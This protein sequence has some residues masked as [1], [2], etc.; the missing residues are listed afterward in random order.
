[1]HCVGF[2]HTM[3]L[4]LH[5]SYIAPCV[6]NCCATCCRLHPSCITH[7]MSLYFAMRLHLYC[8]ICGSILFN[9]CSFVTTRPRTLDGIIFCNVSSLVMCNMWQC[10]IQCLFICNHQALHIACHY[11]LQCFFIGIVQYVAVYYAVPVHL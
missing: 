10:T 8:A 11:I 6:E 1:M 2:Y 3:N 9:A 4:H 7:C 5:P